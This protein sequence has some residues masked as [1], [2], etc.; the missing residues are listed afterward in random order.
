M[1]IREADYKYW[2]LY[3]NS[4]IFAQWP[5]SVQRQANTVW[6]HL[7]VDLRYP[8]C[9]VSLWN[10]V[11]F[12]GPQSTSYISW[13]SIFS[14]CEVNSGYK[15]KKKAVKT[16]YLCQAVVETITNYCHVTAESKNFH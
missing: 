16:K 10:L 13:K 11:D 2:Q 4:H 1:H 9:F 5:H 14:F 8:E 12:S 3:L 15:H 7:V 6:E